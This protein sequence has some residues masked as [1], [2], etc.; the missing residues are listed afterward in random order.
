MPEG[1]EITQ[2]GNIRYKDRFKG[3]DDGQCGWQRDDFLEHSE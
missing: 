3:N 1:R 2:K